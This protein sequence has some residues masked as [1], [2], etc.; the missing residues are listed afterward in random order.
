[1][2]ANGGNKILCSKDFKKLRIAQTNSEFVKVKSLDFHYNGTFLAYNT[3]ESLKI[4]ELT[5]ERVIE[6]FVDC[7]KSGI[8]MIKFWNDEILAS[9][10][11]N[12]LR[13]LDF[14]ERAYIRYFPGHAKEI[15]SIDVTIE[16]AA[17]GSKDQTVRIWDIKTSESI[18]TMKFL[19]TPFVTFYPS[20][21]PDKTKQTLA[22]AHNS[23]TIEVYETRNTSSSQKKFEFE[24]V[25]GVEWTSLKYS[26]DG[27]KFIVTTDS[28]LIKIIDAETGQ[29]IMDIKGE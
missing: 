26:P 16:L 25:D 18:N 4:L 14:T 21:I 7:K 13:L 12:Y 10:N 1:M 15:V 2:A 29:E 6:R 17:S 23:K 8:G 22:V 5:D 28:S 3:N 20:L 11:K 27:K 19:S 24:K 9:C